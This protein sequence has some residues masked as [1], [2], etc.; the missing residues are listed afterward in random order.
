MTEA[1]GPAHA[2]AGD[3]DGG[4]SD[5]ATPPIRPGL[6]SITLRDRGWEE[7]VDRAAEALLAGIEWGGDVHVPP[8]DTVRAAAVADRCR[9]AGLACPSYGSYL[10]AGEVVDGELDAVLDTT[11]ALRATNVRVWCRWLSAA[12]ATDEDRRAITADLA[13]VCEAAAARGL[14][15]SLEH[16]RFTLTETVA[17]TQAL[18][19]DVGS[20]DLFT[21][22]QP[23]DHLAVPELV[24]EV[25]A[26]HAHLSHLHV[27]RWR[28]FEDRLALHE[29]E[30]L[31]PA[32]LAAAASLPGRWRG[33][34]WA[35]LEYVRG[36]DPAQL[37]A[38]A[39]VLRRWLAGPGPRC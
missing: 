29:G 4:H 14:A 16:H 9:G 5:A 12:D 10:R 13:A 30:D 1:P 19:D 25:G 20:P 36:D 38:D 37:L 33:E 31:W 28:S 24:D 21:Y 22:W 35:F 15:V 3:R 39:A 11:E 26:L 32:V 2:V 8:G 23:C 18:L 34:R 27:F 7:V 6:C 17:S